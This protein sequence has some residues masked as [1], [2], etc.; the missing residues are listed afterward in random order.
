MA[1]EKPVKPKAPQAAKP[2]SAD[3]KSAHCKF[4]ACK[5]SNEKFGFCMEH[6]EFYMAGIVRGDGKKPIDFEAKLA[7]YMQQHQKDRKVA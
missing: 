6:Y 7:R 1:N 2:D 4:E 3:A 5:K